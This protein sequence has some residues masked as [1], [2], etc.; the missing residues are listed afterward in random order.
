M[1]DSGEG[2][3]SIDLVYQCLI[4]CDKF[5]AFEAALKLIVRPSS[6]VLDVGTGSG[7][8]AMLAAR[9]GAKDVT[10]IEFDPYIA[11]IARKNVE[12]NGL[13]DRVRVMTGDA[14]S[15]S[16]PAFDIVMME[17]L[18]TGLVDEM[19]VQAI[20]N[21]C[22]QGVIAETTI[23]VPFAQES[24][25]S[26]VQADFVVH[27]FAMRMVSHLWSHDDHS[28]RFKPLSEPQLMNRVTFD[29]EN[30]EASDSSMIFD[31]LTDGEVNGICLSSRTLLNESGGIAIE[32]SSSLNPPVLVPLPQ[33]EVS[34]GDRVAIDV[35]YR[36]GGSFKN[37]SVQYV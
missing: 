18:A 5:R 27:G 28:S 21:L 35:R 36:F 31:I 10:A 34:R 15:I 9:L 4:D 16:P 14:R 30:A 13:G 2:F 6:R 37:F 8:L 7:L 25:V 24:H 32:S 3:S 17:M 20:N 11:E 19:Q 12:D 33:K 26:L 23:V 29:R 22:D 1:T